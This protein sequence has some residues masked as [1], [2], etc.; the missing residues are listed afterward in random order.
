ML[1]CKFEDRNAQNIFSN[2][3]VIG[4]AKDLASK[5]FST[6]LTHS[7]DSINPQV[8]I[9]MMHAIEYTAVYKISNLVIIENDTVQLPKL[10]RVNVTT[11]FKSKKL[12]N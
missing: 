11:V 6:D 2:K 1:V 8:S 12:S 3:N 7:T 5:K 4:W 9:W 10:L